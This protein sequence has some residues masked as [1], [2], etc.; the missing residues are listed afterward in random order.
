LAAIFY[1]TCYHG[2]AYVLMRGNGRELAAVNPMGLFFTNTFK[3][4]QGN[5][6]S[7]RQGLVRL[8]YAERNELTNLSGATMKLESSRPLGLN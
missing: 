6:V 3:G 4:S 1:T 5:R 7:L 2:E 8:E